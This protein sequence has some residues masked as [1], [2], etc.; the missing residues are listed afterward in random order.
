MIRTRY[1]AGYVIASDALLLLTA[2]PLQR[3]ALG[4]ALSPQTGAP[5]IAALLALNLL[6][7][8]LVVTAALASCGVMARVAVYAGRS[9][10]RK[11][12]GLPEETL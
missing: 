3:Y 2:L 11:P 9:L 10:T 12:N 7:L 8:I 6:L 1:L 5:V 4:A